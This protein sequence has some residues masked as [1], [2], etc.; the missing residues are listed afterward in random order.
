MG[1][2]EDLL[3]LV[4]ETCVVGREMRLGLLD[5]LVVVRTCDEDPAGA[6]QSSGHAGDDT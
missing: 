6:G 3:A 5:K 1:E 4:L 2:E